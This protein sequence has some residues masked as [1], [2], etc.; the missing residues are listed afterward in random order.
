MGRHISTPSLDDPEDD[1]QFEITLG[2]RNDLTEKLAYDAYYTRFLRNE[3]GDMR[4]ER[5]CRKDFA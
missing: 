3:T 1:A 4:G 5:F 2:H